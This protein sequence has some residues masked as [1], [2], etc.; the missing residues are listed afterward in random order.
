MD[1]IECIKER[2]TN[3]NFKKRMKSSKRFEQD[4]DE[5]ERERRLEMKQMPNTLTF[6][7]TKMKTMTSDEIC[8][9]ISIYMSN[10]SFEYV[11][12][13]EEEKLKTSERYCIDEA[14]RE[15]KR[16]EDSQVLL[17]PLLMIRRKDRK[18]KIIV[19]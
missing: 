4:E 18:R 5:E 9:L 16:D 14:E 19:M 3:E 11:T 1:L 13:R 6:M 2:L 17:R 15:K 10:C 8:K 7:T 12:R